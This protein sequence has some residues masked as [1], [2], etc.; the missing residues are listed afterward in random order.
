MA[1]AATNPAFVDPRGKSDFDAGLL[2]FAALARLY[3]GITWENLR[4]PSFS[5]SAFMAGWLTDLGHAV[6]KTTR[7]VGGIVSDATGLIGSKAGQA[8]RLASD[9]NVAQTVT[10]AGA[11]IATGGA[12]EGAFTASSAIGK[13][14][15]S[16]GQKVVE[17]TGAAYKG[18]TSDAAGGINWSSPWVIGGA[19]I[20]A[21][22]AVLA[23]RPS[24]QYVQG[25][26]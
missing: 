1:G 24:P 5:K 6:A 22:V 4:S 11:A 8:V 2:Y 25:R 14:L 10:R 16:A 23:F 21:L 3:P 13:I 9:P 19:G 18:A 12:S 15:S 20:A 17:A 7:S 26:R